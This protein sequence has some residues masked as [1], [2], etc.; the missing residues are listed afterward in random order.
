M[1]GLGDRLK[2]ARTAKGFTLDDLQSI[3]KIQKRYLA[4]IENEDYSM[5]PGSFYVRAFI[6]QYAEAVGLDAEEM[7]SLYKESVPVAELK[8]QENQLVQPTVRR[9]MSRRNSRFV[10]M[11]PKITVALFIIVII[12]VVYFLVKH[13]AS[14][15]PQI[16]NHGEQEPIS[17]QDSNKPDAGES[18]DTTDEKGKEDQ[19]MEEPVQ[20]EEPEKPEQTLTNVSVNGQ[21]STY[22]LTGAA[23]FKLEI[24]AVGNSWIGVVDSAQQERMTPGA[25]EMKAGETV[26]LDVS[27]TDS[28]R[29][30]VGYSPSTEIYVNGELLEYVSERT[31]QTIA[32]EYVKE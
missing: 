6:K 30:R 21:L 23:E 4:G 13:N 10:E 24:R 20:P 27:D 16:E 19:E 22:S 8:D 25:R 3:T 15:Q 29:I 2:E 7:L 17:M 9:R 32:I 14:K 5:M 12:F 28:V 11:M 31:T 18:D 26:E 1:T